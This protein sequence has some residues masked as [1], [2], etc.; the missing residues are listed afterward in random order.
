MKILANNKVDYHEGR[1][2]LLDAHTIDVD[3]KTFTV[4][5]ATAAGSVR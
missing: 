4:R 3:G 5:D 2:K 1:G